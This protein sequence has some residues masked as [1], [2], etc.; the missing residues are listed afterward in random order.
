MSAADVKVGSSAIVRQI[1]HIRESFDCSLG[2][3]NGKHDDTK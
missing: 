3:Y 1:K 2:T